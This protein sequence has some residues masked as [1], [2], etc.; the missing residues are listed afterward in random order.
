[1]AQLTAK[2]AARVEMSG[3]ERLGLRISNMINHPIAQ[4]QRWVT[5]L[6]LENDVDEDWE[7]VME[8]LSAID[9]L[10]M[11]VVDDRAVTLS[12]DQRAIEEAA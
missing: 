9:D 1:M 10:K 12:W 4:M 5:I 6:R 8:A 11:T 2:P 7:E 3:A